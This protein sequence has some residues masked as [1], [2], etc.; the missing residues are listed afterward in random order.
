M[1]EGVFGVARTQ[2]FTVVGPVNYTTE[3]ANVYEAYEQGTFSARRAGNYYVEVCA[4]A[5]VCTAG[6]PAPFTGES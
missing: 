1:W 2:P 3:L 6:S 4:G 5:Q